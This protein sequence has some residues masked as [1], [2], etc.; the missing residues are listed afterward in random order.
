MERERG[1]GGNPLL[2]FPPK[3]RLDAVGCA[4]LYGEVR[5]DL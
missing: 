2:G 1:V 3:L 5:K 4:L